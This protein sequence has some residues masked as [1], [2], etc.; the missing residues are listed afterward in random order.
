MADPQINPEEQALRRRARRRLV[1]SLA[2]ALLAVF[3]LPMVFEP[4]PKPLGDDVEI[5]IPG[6]DTPFKPT[7]PPAAPATP[8]AA[9][10]TTSVT[11]APEPAASN[12]ISAPVVPVPLAKPAAAIPPAKL[13][14][15]GDTKAPPAKAEAKPNTPAEVKPAAKSESK[16]AEIKPITKGEAKPAETKPSVKPDAKLDTKPEAKPEAKNLAKVEEKT[17]EA[18]NQYLQLGSFGAEANAR[19]LADKLKAAGFPVKVLS[20]QGAYKVRVGPY[21]SKDKA[22]E[23]QAKL[24]AKGHAPV[25]VAP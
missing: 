1:G 12:P 3:V 13:V 9:S 25:L 23:A 16:P 15:P 2:L 6:Q 8:K 18:G 22:V 10:E 7:T 19:Q 24:K 20:A 5:V 17:A 14:M 11:P 21:P 4:E